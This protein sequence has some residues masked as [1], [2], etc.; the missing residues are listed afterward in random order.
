MIE[1]DV[2]NGTLNMTDRRENESDLP[3]ATLLTVHHD[4]DRQGGAP[5]THPLQGESA[6]HHHRADTSNDGD[7]KKCIT[8]ST[9]PTTKMNIT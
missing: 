3:R 1:G 2:P 4:G 7:M 8:I 5:T 6:A 9:V